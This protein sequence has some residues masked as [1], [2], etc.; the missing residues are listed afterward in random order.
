MALAFSFGVP[1]LRWE[2][3]RKMQE[4]SRVVVAL[5]TIL[6]SGGG[7]PLLKGGRSYRILGDSFDCWEIK[8]E[9][10]VK[11]FFPKTYFGEKRTKEKVRVR[12]KEGEYF[13]VR[14]GKKHSRVRKIGQ[15]ES[16]LVA[17]TDVEE[18]ED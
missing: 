10:G 5:E 4:K 13:L 12:G 14:G 7:E 8:A 9:T 6:K 16:I 11:M 3:V 1:F 2:S 15:E 18:V 17:S